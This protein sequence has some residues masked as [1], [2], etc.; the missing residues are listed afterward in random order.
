MLLGLRF[1]VKG[2]ILRDLEAAMLQYDKGQLVRMLE[3]QVAL[4]RLNVPFTAAVATHWTSRA[5]F[6]ASAITT[7]MSQRWHTYGRSSMW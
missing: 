7:A 5:Q 2:D 3:S 4:K 6:S 1:L